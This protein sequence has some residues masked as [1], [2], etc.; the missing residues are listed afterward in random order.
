ML[1][2]YEVSHGKFAIVEAGPAGVLAANYMSKAE[3][4]YG[5]RV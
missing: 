2:R 4:P 3:L 1:W 5:D